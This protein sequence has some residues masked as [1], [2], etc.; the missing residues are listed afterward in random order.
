[1]IKKLRKKLSKLR[2]KYS[3]RGK[4]L[5]DSYGQ[6]GED[7]ILASYFPEAKG[8]YVDVGAHHP[9]KYS[10]TYRFYRMGWRGINIDPVPGMKKIFDKVRPRDVNVELGIGSKEDLI[11]YYMFNEAAL[12]TF[13]EKVVKSLESHPT[14]KLINEID[15]KI[16]PLAKVLDEYLSAGTQIDFLTIDVEGL[17]FEVLQ[18]NDWNKYR[19][20]AVVCE[21]P[22]GT[23]G[24]ISD[25]F[26]SD[27]CKFL[28]E[29]GYRF[30]AK[31]VNTMFFLQK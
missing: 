30:V 24:E 20:R 9:K 3:L 13:D 16:L 8:F 4:Y 19:P 17:D 26:G 14:F 15:V 22:L 10:N 6:F 5:N 12:N 2:K 29:R 28:E 18:S 1:M 23:S 27:L 21:V 7:M 25:I 31:T 11:P